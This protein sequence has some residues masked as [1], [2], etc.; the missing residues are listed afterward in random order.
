MA[1]LSKVCNASVPFD[2]TLE[3]SLVPV[4]TMMA[5]ALPS[6]HAYQEHAPCPLW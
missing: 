6:L 4:R 1:A 3:G 2:G 5:V